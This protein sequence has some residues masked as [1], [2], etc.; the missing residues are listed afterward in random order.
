MNVNLDN[1]YWDR[2]RGYVTE[3]RVDARWVL[4]IHGCPER[5]IPENEMNEE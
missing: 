2:L 5:V 3:L 4:T 1:T